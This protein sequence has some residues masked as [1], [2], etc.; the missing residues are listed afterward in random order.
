MSHQPQPLIPLSSFPKPGTDFEA[1]SESEAS[2]RI[3]GKTEPGAAANVALSRLRKTGIGFVEFFA[4]GANA[5]HQA[6][7]AALSL[8]S[9][10]WI[11][12]QIPA[13]VVPRW[14]TTQTT[15]PISK[16]VE[17]KTGIV[18]R[19]VVLPPETVLTESGGNTVSTS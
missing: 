9:I 4:I 11:H 5:G 14:A 6:V 17:Q 18:L 12:H 2:I 10:L 16:V 15:D 7:K 8:I 19:V 1:Y 13:A 3:S